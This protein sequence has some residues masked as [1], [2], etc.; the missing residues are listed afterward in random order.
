ME[1][2]KKEWK[3]KSHNHISIYLEKLTQCILFN[4]RIVNNAKWGSEDYI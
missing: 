1:E 2:W 3:V 4:H